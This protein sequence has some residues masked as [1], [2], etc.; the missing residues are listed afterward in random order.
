MKLPKIMGQCRTTCFHIIWSIRFFF[1][2]LCSLDT[3]HFSTSP[4]PAGKRN[5]SIS[6]N[7]QSMICFLILFYLKI[8][9]ERLFTALFLSLQL[10]FRF[11]FIYLFAS[12]Y[13]YLNLMHMKL[14]SIMWTFWFLQNVIQISRRQP[15]IRQSLWEPCTFSLTLSGHW[16]SL[17]N[18]LRFCFRAFLFLILTSMLVLSILTFV[19]DYQ[20]AFYVHI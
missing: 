17:I 4:L 18:Q 1:L 7:F 11:W 13:L 10:Y 14:I 5:K 3:L 15:T 9:N 20:I 16:Y 19:F 8:T 12:I 2:H 6:P